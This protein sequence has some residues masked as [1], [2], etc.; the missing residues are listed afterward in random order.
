MS[1][2]ELELPFRQATPEDARALAE[3]VDMASEHMPSCV[4]A[5]MAEP[6]EDAWDVGCRRARREAG[7]FSY[8]NAIVAEVEGQVAGCL[9]GYPLPAEAESFGPHRMPPM[10]VPLQELEDLASGT[11]YVNVLATYPRYRGQ[12]YGTRFL[13]LAEALAAASGQGALSLIVSDANERA[14]RLYLRCGFRD[15][16]RRPLVKGEGWENAGTSWVLMR[17]SL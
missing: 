11:W 3:L 9:I 1:T 13:R 15:A 5:R 2:I 7:S 4:W 10:F 14:R 6:G 12:G 16:A 8:R 17:K